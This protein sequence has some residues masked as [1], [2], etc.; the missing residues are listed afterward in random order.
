MALRK[1]GIACVLMS[2]MSG[3]GMQALAAG[4]DGNGADQGVGLNIPVTKVIM[5]REWNAKDKYE[6]TLSAIGEV[7]GMTLPTKTTLEIN[8]KSVNHTAKFEA[9][10]F[11]KE[12]KGALLQVAEKDGDT[13]VLSVDAKADKEG[14]MDVT[15]TVGSYDEETKKFTAGKGAKTILSV[16]TDKADAETGSV[17]VNW[18]VMI[19][20]EGRDFNTKDNFGLKFNSPNETNPMPG[21]DSRQ[22]ALGEK[23][24]AYLVVGP[25]AYTEPGTYEYTVTQDY[26]NAEDKDTVTYDAA[27]YKVIVTTEASEDGVLSATTWRRDQTRG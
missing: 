17:L 23:N 14:K 7:E 8:E 1:K 26:E 10:T 18:P 3:L 20:M 22:L 5:G 21:A 15:Y 9:V 13:W 25:I 4:A 27:E 12:A 24:L 16:T 6:F 2:S 19:S 11:A